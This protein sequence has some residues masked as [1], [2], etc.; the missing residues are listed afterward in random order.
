MIDK[1]NDDNKEKKMKEV[2]ENMRNHPRL[3]G[4]QV[5]KKRDKIKQFDLLHNK[6]E[7]ECEER[8]KEI[9]TESGET[10][11]SMKHF[12]AVAGIQPNSVRLY[13]HFGRIPVRH[14]RRSGWHIYINV[15]ALKLIEKTRAKGA[16]ARKK[17]LFWNKV[18]GKTGRRKGDKKTGTDN[19]KKVK[20]PFKPKTGI[21]KKTAA[22]AKQKK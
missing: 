21:L 10:Y 4:K 13:R 5:L 19:E 20:A 16:E 14:I 6:V 7:Y 2:T 9:I 1:L 22:R 8:G 11:Y 17:N 12:A 15:K 18:E 3:K